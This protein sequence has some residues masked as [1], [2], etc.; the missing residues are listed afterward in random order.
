MILGMLKEMKD[1]EKGEEKLK[2]TKLAV[3]DLMLQAELERS[4]PTE[5]EA[6]SAPGG[7]GTQGT[8]KNVLG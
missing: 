7:G 1:S 3:I 4:R 2:S 8:L 5:G 6:L